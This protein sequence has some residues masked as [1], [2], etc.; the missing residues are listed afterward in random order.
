MITVTIWHNV[1]CDAE[2]HHTAMLDGYQPGDPMVRVFT[3]LADPA[4]RPPE[5]IA[6]EA[7]GTFNDHPGSPEG[8][9]LARRYYRHRLLRSLSGTS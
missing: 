2:G 1:A 9:E 5:E 3:Y 6:K 8:E 4:G 7:F